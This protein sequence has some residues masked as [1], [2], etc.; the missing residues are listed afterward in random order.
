[1]AYAF[2]SYRR[3]DTSDEAARV[4]DA[5]RKILG[6]DRVFMDTCSIE[7]GVEWSARIHSALM[8]STH[9]VVVVGPNWVGEDEHG[10]SRRMDD[11]DDWVRQVVAFALQ[12]RKNVIPV[13]VSGGALPSEDELPSDAAPIVRLQAVEVRRNYFEHDLQLVTKRASGSSNLNLRVA[14]VARLQTLPQS[15]MDKRWSSELLPV[16]LQ[17]S[18]ILIFTADKPLVCFC[19]SACSLSL[20]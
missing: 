12:E 10:D 15:G 16:Q 3:D 4:A 9:V 2:V 8:K 17:N 20:A 7:P 14:G 6:R 13:L 18:R 11:E 1:M 19:Q 5:L